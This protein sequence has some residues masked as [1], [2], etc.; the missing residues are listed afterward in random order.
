M[1][2]FQAN[3]ATEAVPSVACPHPDAD[4]NV[5]AP[6]RLAR[7][8][9]SS[10]SESQQEA[11]SCGL[12]KKVFNRRENLSRHLK[13]HNTPSHSCSICGKAFTRS[14]LM[15]RHEASHERW[16]SSAKKSG[17]RPV[18]RR[19]QNE[20]DG[21]D[22][23]SNSSDFIARQNSEMLDRVPAH[24]PMT[25]HGS[26]FEAENYPGISPASHIQHSEAMLSQPQGSMAGMQS[27]RHDSSEFPYDIDMSLE[28][29]D[30]STFLVPQDITP[31]GHEWFSFDFYSAMRETGNEL[32]RLRGIGPSPA[33]ANTWGSV[34]EQG[35]Q[36]SS[37]LQNRPYQGLHQDG[38]I[39]RIS[40]PPNEA[41]EEDKWPFQWN[42][43]AQQILSAHP[44]SIPDSHPLFHA[45][46]PRFDITEA[47][48]SELESFLQPQFA[49]YPLGKPP[50][51]LPPLNVIN[52]FIGL[53][54]KRFS[55][56]MPVLHHATINTNNDLPPPLIAAMIV[57][58]A[59]YSHLKH[60]RRF[61]IVL[62]NATRW[63]LQIAVES[64]NAL[65]RSPMIIYAEALIVHTGLWC[66]NKRAFELAEVGRGALV[67]YVRRIKFGVQLPMSNPHSTT[68][69]NLDSA[70]RR[71]IHEESQKR[72]AWVVYTID[73]QFP[74]LLNL[75]P[76]TSVGEVRNLGCPCDEE[77][78]AAGSARSWKNLLGPAT[79]PPSRS[80]AAAVGPFVLGSNL[81]DVNDYSEQ[82]PAR[83]P[84]LILNPWSAF[85]VLTTVTHQI[86]Q[87]TQE[88][89]VSRTFIDEDEWSPNGAGFHGSDE[90][91][92]L[93][94]RSRIADT[95][96]SFYSSYLSSHHPTRDASTEY[97]NRSSHILHRLS[98]I[99]LSVPLPDLQNTIGKDGTAG[100]AQA[101]SS[102]SSWARI[103]SSNAEQVAQHAVQAIMSLSP[104][105]SQTQT[106][107]YLDTAP[108]SLI[109]IFLSHIILWVFM[110]VSAKEQ[111]MQLLRRL[112]L[113]VDLRSSS[114][115]SLLRS[116]MEVGEG[117]GKVQKKVLFRSG[118]EMLTRFGTWGA[119]L[120]L[121]LLL[122]R[123]AEM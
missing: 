78:W 7:S 72:L 67:T 3:H 74:S 23:T 71:W 100:V 83:L 26:D 118:A 33:S 117:D 41:S 97:F 43:N 98:T 38:P 15:K 58:G 40:S 63:Q 31:T 1:S 53:F 44:V 66:G 17:R 24:S 57:I 94:P 106:S 35:E 54:F 77:F 115:I 48:L 101:M 73:S 85:L 13:T 92:S 105:D 28:P 27:N 4:P 11:Y 9:A 90:R 102:L 80:F 5:V 36:P 120:N 88:D 112:E 18:K 81:A 12:C 59:I 34:D 113:D 82:R 55:P 39:S 69:S 123:R 84:V 25:S 2:T 47:T 108:Y 91:N 20:D 109:A 65:M 121:A 122:Q 114:F 60:T 68:S 119:S 21:R 45:H 111:R 56:Q 110:S 104:P 50:F 49:E 61:A 29:F 89:V 95:L 8:T 93:S 46:D 32:G 99:L 6:E 96:R 14:D 75:P 19:K 87:I 70:W 76:T 30:F 64:N 37:E 79:V 52:V 16:D 103:S 10:R 42:P 22:V 86:F 51:V 116:D 62:L 107:G